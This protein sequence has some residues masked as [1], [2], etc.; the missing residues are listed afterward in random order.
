M[1]RQCS[2]SPNKGSKGKNESEV[3]KME[4]VTRQLFSPLSHSTRTLLP[5][6]I[7]QLMGSGFRAD[8]KKKKYFFIQCDVNLRNCLPQDL[9]MIVGLNGSDGLLV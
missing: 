2:H 9:V 7:M 1:G 8:L 6:Y 5:G 4:R 3:H